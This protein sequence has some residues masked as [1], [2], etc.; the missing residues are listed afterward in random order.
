MLI[1]ILGFLSYC[2]KVCNYYGWLQRQRSLGMEGFPSSPEMMMMMLT[3]LACLPLHSVRISKI[4]FHPWDGKVMDIS[5]T[6][7][8][9]LPSLSLIARDD[10]D[11]AG[12]LASA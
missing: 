2:L 8:E 12:L 7:G 6:M 1:S 10:D 9:K 11:F 4:F 5:L 3:S